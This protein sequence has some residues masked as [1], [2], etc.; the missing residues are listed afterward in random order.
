HNTYISGEYKKVV[1][2]SKTTYLS[3]AEINSRK[4][5]T[6]FPKVSM[7]SNFYI[8]QF[9]DLNVGFSGAFKS[10][11]EDLSPNLNPSLKN[12]NFEYDGKIGLTFKFENLK[13]S[14]DFS[15]N[16]INIPFI[17]SG[18]EIENISMNLGLSYSGFEF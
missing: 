16:L 5:F 8:T 10:V 11:I 14:L 12:S 1:Y 9:L 15:K 2:N 3:S 7:G 17:I 13:I 18:K 6:Y 4:T